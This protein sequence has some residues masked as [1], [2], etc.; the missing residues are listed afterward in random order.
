MKK[1][2]NNSIRKEGYTRRDFIKGASCAALGLAMGVS[3][4]SKDLVK[5]PT[6]TKVILIR[7]KAAVGPNGKCNVEIIQKMID[8]AVNTL[9]DVDS[10]V[11]A[12]STMFKPDD[13]VGVKTNVWGPLP[14]PP[15]VEQS[16]KRGILS[17]GVKEKNIGIDDRGVLGNGIFKKATALVNVRPMRTHHWAGV[18]GLLK[19]HIMFC[20]APWDYHDNSCADLAAVWNL[21]IIRDKTRLNILVMMT[22][23]FHGIGAHHFDKEFTWK[24]NGLLVG[25]DPVAI[26]AVGLQILKAKRLAYFGEERPMKPSPHHI[27]FADTKHNL[28]VADMNKINLIKLGWDEDILINI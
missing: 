6:G 28:G 12:W 24:Y 15:E 2:D 18:G 20:P 13:I 11:K 5:A 14:T 27:A 26:D 25:T 21:S 10:P 16:I 7:D 1:N 19:N 22:P 3:A 23:L 9:F 8:R 4:D 17:A